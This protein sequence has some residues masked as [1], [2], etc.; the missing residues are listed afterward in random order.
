MEPVGLAVGIIGLAGLFSSC[1]DVLER[2]DSWKD[3]S[4]DS[5][6]LAARFEADK[7]RF[8]KWGQAV[9][10]GQ[11]DLLDYHHET[12]N[13][14][15]TLATV[16][17]LLSVIR[18]IGNDSEI[19]FPST[20]LGPDAPA[21]SGISFKVKVHPTESTRRRL[22]WAMRD[23]AKRIAQVEQFGQLVDRLYILVPLTGPSSCGNT[24]GGTDGKRNFITPLIDISLIAYLGNKET[25]I[26]EVKRIF[27]KFGEEIEGW[28]H[29]TSRS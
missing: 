1:L 3:F 2:F 11:K 27:N 4:N 28:S 24:F 5:R 13:D 22:G 29:G 8:E 19:R 16:E 7:L 20:F 18:D 26:A 12:L 6:A 10:V 23:K 17:G 15:R 14:P 9:G 25:W 21:K